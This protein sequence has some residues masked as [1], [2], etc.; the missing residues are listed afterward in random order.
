MRCWHPASSEKI[1]DNEGRDVYD[2]NE[3]LSEGGLYR[4]ETRE[5]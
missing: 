3:D 1:E 2:L 5:E 4:A